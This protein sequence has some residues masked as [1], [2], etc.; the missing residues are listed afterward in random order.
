M[1]GRTLHWISRL[2]LGTLFLIAGIIKL[3]NP[4]LFEMAVDSYQLLP[5]TGV[6]VVARSLPWLEVV[7][8]MLLLK[9][10]KL[11]YMATFTAL[12]LGA[13]LAAMSITYARGIEANCGCFGLN[14]RI[15]PF[16]LARDSVLFALAAFLAVTARRRLRPTHT[17]P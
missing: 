13:F 4:F 17:A 8:G 12:L 15:S 1:L 3:A 10:W 6:I 5:P 7:L 9:G 11:Q 16:T 14:E 2:V